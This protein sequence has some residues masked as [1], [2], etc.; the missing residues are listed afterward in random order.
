MPGALTLVEVVLNAVSLSLSLAWGSRRCWSFAG[1]VSVG[2]EIV[3]VGQMAPI[4]PME[5]ETI[6]AEMTVDDSVMLE[7]GVGCVAEGILMTS[8]V[9]RN[10]GSTPNINTGPEIGDP[11]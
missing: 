11:S 7:V 9:R 3:L 5:E 6:P 10:E 4:I 2:F 1:A 8:Q